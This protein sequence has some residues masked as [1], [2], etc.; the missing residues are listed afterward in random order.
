MS[1]IQ[2]AWCWCEQN[3]R[4]RDSSVAMCYGL[5]R[6]GIGVRF[7]AGIRDISVLYSVYTGFRAFSAC[8]PLGA[9]GPISRG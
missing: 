5:D 7:S 1:V 2:F 3:G 9:E 8:Y 6:Q 4:S